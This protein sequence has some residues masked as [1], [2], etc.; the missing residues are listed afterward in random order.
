MELEE[1]ED[2]V[3]EK[4]TREDEDPKPWAVLS[5]REPPNR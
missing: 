3:Q 5:L 1:P 2:F 4:Y